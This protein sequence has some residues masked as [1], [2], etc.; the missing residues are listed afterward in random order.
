[1]DEKVAM[2]RYIVHVSETCH[3]STIS[4][5]P[6]LEGYPFS[7]AKTVSDGATLETSSGVLYFY[8][9]PMDYT[10][11]DLEVD[12]RASVSFTL[13]E[14]YCAD[15]DWIAQ[16]PRCPRLLITGE[17]EA[18][19]GEEKEVARAALFERYPVMEFWPEDH[20]FFFTKLVPRSILLL[21]TFGGAADIAPEEYF[22]ATT[23][24]KM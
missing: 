11:A 7:N 19:E 14:S 22:A 9:S 2:A 3:M 16:D 20:G 4:T 10:S 13:A 15:M 8:T 24:E 18:V 21:D 6:G 5:V 23:P 1:V 17:V 12:A